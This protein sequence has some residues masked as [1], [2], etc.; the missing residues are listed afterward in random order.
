M[1]LIMISSLMYLPRFM[2]YAYAREAYVIVIANFFSGIC[3]SLFVVAAMQ[4][5]ESIT[6]PELRTSMFGLV[7]G[8]THGMAPMVANIC[9][10]MYYQQWGGQ[11]M[12]FSAAILGAVWSIFIFFYVIFYGRFCNYKAENE[13]EE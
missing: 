1:H 13:V 2:M 9:G 5:A 7:S 10:G 8:L 3:Y 4:Q 12:Y 11:N 6:A